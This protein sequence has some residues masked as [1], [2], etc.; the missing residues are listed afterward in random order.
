MAADRIRRCGT[1]VVVRSSDLDQLDRDLRRAVSGPDEDYAAVLERALAVCAADR[2]VAEELDELELHSELADVYDRMGRVDDALKHADVLAVRG[3]R[4]APDPRCRRAEI[5]MRHG[6]ADEAAPIWDAVL[7]DWPDDVWV[8]NN[9]G[10]EYGAIGEHRVALRW[11]TLGLELAVRTGDPERLVPQLRRLRAES[12]AAL[13]RETDELQ[14][15][16]PKGPPRLPA[17]FSAVP[18]PIAPQRSAGHRAG[19]AALAYAWLPADEFA[20]IE[21][22]WPEIAAED[23]VRDSGALVDHG[24]Y[25]RRLERT[26][27]EAAEAGLRRLRVA[28]LRR[29]AF[30]AWVTAAGREGE[31]EAEL[32]AGYAAELN[33]RGVDVVA[34]PPGRNERCWCGSGVKYKKCCALAVRL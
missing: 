2:S 16:E 20:L 14:T 8:F 24:E 25:C 19:D 6:R 22:R 3:Y 26:L 34:W 32:R 28:T 7:R 10:L 21:Q 4:C 9:A 23:S 1:I 15:A 12:L 33:R 31:D 13:G 5:L 11:L 30:D 27:R 18:P 29:A 17:G